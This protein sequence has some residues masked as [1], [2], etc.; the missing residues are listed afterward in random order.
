MPVS[1]NTRRTVSETNELFQSFIQNSQI[2]EDRGA[3]RAAVRHDGTGTT[4]SRFPVY[5]YLCS[6]NINAQKWLIFRKN[7][8]PHSVENLT[9]TMSMA[10]EESDYNC[11]L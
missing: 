4:T 8:I 3:W 2:S 9:Q 1:K 10:G 7:L 6:L 11:G 5:E